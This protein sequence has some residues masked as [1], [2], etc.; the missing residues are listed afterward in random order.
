MIE[1]E[2]VEVIWRREK[3]LVEN[4]A[5]LDSIIAR[6]EDGWWKRFDGKKAGFGFRLDLVYQGEMMF[7]YVAN[8]LLNN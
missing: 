2:K 4:K 6:F 5:T 1:C 8:L 3:K 7:G